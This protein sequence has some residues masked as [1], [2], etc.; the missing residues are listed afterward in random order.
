M[1]S[2]FSIFL[3]GVKKY[4]FVIFS[5][6]IMSCSS[7]E[8]NVSQ[9][10][11][12]FTV[13]TTGSLN[14]TMGLK[15][16]RSSPNSPSYSHVKFVTC[17]G[18]VSSRGD[19]YSLEVFDKADFSTSNEYNLFVKVNGSDKKAGS[20]TVKWSG[21]PESL[22][23]LIYRFDWWG[24][25]YNKSTMEKFG[26]YFTG[27]VFFS[28]ALACP[29]S[30]GLTCGYALSTAG[31]TMAAIGIGT[32]IK[33]EIKS[34]SFPQDKWEAAEALIKT[35]AT[36]YGYDTSGTPVLPVISETYG[37]LLDIYKKMLGF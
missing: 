27:A 7:G 25:S 8:E 3:A 37:I 34:I 20:C 30:A 1:M 33:S 10:Q 19:R 6:F 18:G 17:W 36:P 9:L 4:L 32:F 21:T 13:D 23:T 2:H 16:Y 15:L 12:S 24:Y 26:L 11:Q 14:N 31:A 35:K 5:M 22:N 29:I 28:S